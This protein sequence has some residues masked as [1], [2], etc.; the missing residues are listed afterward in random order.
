MIPLREFFKQH[1]PEYTCHDRPAIPRAVS[2]AECRRACRRWC[3]GEQ[4]SS[5]P[6]RRRSCGRSPP[7][8]YIGTPARVHVMVC[9]FE[10]VLACVLVR[11]Y[12]LSLQVCRKAILHGLM[13]SK[14]HTS[15]L[16]KRGGSVNTRLVSYHVVVEFTPAAVSVGVDEDHIVAAVVVAAGNRRVK[17]EKRNCNY[18]R[19]RRYRRL[20]EPTSWKGF[21]I[22]HTRL[23][24][25]KKTSVHRARAIVGIRNLQKQQNTTGK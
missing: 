3:S 9:R 17:V 10:C 7:S 24:T 23:I 16:C 11:R 20:R 19:A 21:G 4:S 5:P 15:G 12:Q 13:G 18:G 2:A 25:S 22:W 1:L 14:V 8:W 6:P